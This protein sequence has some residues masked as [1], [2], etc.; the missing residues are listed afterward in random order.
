MQQASTLR[1]TLVSYFVRERT[2]SRAARVLAGCSQC[3]PKQTL[4]HA[5]R[6]SL[7]FLHTPTPSA[8]FFS[9]HTTAQYTYATTN[10][11]RYPSIPTAPCRPSP[12]Y[13]RASA[14][15]RF[16]C[17]IHVALARPPYAILAGTGLRGAVLSYAIPPANLLPWPGL[18]CPALSFVCPTR[19]LTHHSFPSSFAL[20]LLTTSKHLSPLPSFPPVH[21][22]LL[23]FPTF[24]PP[25]RAESSRVESSPVLSCPAVL[26]RA[27]LCHA[28][29]SVLSSLF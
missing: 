20:Y 15:S 3:P 4:N 29:L 6:V 8:L 1:S 16:F 27:V 12:A 28:R 17:S 26:C 11:G 23:S 10:L 9:H 18:A 25:C 22:S 5:L 2:R 7:P 21:T 19:P 24:R 14:G 13:A